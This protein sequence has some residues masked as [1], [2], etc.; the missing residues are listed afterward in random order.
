M[1]DRIYWH[2]GIERY[3]PTDIGFAEDVSSILLCTAIM[4]RLTAGVP[5]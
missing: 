5:D 2:N 1:K 3:K 4:R